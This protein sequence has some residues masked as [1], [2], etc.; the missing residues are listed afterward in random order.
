MKLKVARALRKVRRVNWGE[1]VASIALSGVAVFISGFTGAAAGSIIL[2]TSDFLWPWALGG[3]IVVPAIV[4]VLLVLVY[5]IK[6]AFR[7][8]EEYAN[9]A[10]IEEMKW[11]RGEYK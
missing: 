6:K 11:E 7:W 9:D 8:G 10:D 3:V 5:I 1:V 2:Q 4:A